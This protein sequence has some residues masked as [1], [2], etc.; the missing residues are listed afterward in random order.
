[1]FWKKPISMV[2]F[3]DYQS[4][5]NQIAFV[6]KQEILGKPA[7][8]LKLTNKNGDVSFFYFDISSGLL[9]KW[10]RHPQN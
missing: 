3:I 10:D 9:L 2:P 7:Y 6:D 8:K 5:G 4:K 1:M